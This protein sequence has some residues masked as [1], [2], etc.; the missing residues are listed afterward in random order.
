MHD[1]RNTANSETID[2]DMPEHMNECMKCCIYG[3]MYV[4]M[5]DLQCLMYIPAIEHDWMRVQVDWM[6]EW[7]TECMNEWMNEDNV[8]ICSGWVHVQNDC[9]TDRIAK[10][11]NKPNQWMYT[12]TKHTHT[13][14][15][16]HTHEWAHAWTCEHNMYDV[17]NE[18]MNVW[19]HEW[20]HS[21]MT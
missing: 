18:S 11:N 3:F 7:M 15:N 8:L 17:V 16:P 1:C 6:T 12:S 10:P 20:M 13:H 14:T 2:K 4:W 5:V 9:M 19:M 21:W